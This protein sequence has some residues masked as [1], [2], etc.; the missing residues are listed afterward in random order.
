M[1]KSGDELHC[2]VMTVDS[3]LTLRIM[4]RRVQNPALNLR[5]ETS[6]EIVFIVTEPVYGFTETRAGTSKLPALLT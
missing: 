1:R 4:P 5:F 2:V 6:E 3:S